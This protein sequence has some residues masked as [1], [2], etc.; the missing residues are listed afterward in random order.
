MAI[1]ETCKQ[2]SDAEKGKIEIRPAT[3]FV[4]ESTVELDRTDKNKD[5]FISVTCRYR[6]SAG[7]SKKNNYVIQV[8]RFET[9]TTE[10]VVVIYSISALGGEEQYSRYKQKVVSVIRNT[11]YE[12]RT[13]RT[14]CKFRAYIRKNQ[15]W[16]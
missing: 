3:P 13:R 11:P 10:D 5:E 16:N 12:C 8:K 2:A 1:S 7:D 6:S 9:G 14:N 15:T 4:P